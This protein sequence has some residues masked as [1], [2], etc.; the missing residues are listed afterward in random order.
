MRGAFITRL[1]NDL[2][3]SIK[4]VMVAARHNTASASATYQR[5]NVESGS[6]R[7]M[8]LMKMCNPS[9]GGVPNSVEP[10]ATVGKSANEE[11]ENFNDG[12]EDLAALNDMCEKTWGKNPP[13]VDSPVVVALKEK[14]GIS[15]AHRYDNS[16]SPPVQSV[17]VKSHSSP[18]HDE[19]SRSSFCGSQQQQGVRDNF[20]QTFSEFT[21][22]ELTKLEKE[23]VVLKNSPEHKFLPLREA[24][25]STSTAAATKSSSYHHSSLQP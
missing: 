1:A 4:E 19:D 6:N 3:I 11:D 25:P 13:V 2:S 22:N 18:T 9:T 24:V 23:I 14:A 15:T 8:A 21:Q 16:F 20:K 17:A 10:D 7:I 12:S 5:S